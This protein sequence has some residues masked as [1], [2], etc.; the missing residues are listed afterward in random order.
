MRTH[1]LE[2]CSIK[3]SDPGGKGVQREGRPALRAGSASSAAS[4]AP[5]AHGKDEAGDEENQKAPLDPETKDRDAALPW[6]FRVLCFTYSAVGL[7]MV[8]RVQA[9][10]CNCPQYPWRVEAA[11]LLLQGLLSFLHDGY[12]AGSSPAAKLADRTSAT[13][14]T[15]CQPLKFTFCRMDAVQLG[16][17]FVSW[18]L[19]LLFFRAAGRAYASGDPRRYQLLHSLW[20]VAL[21]LGGFLWIEYTRG[22]LS[23]RLS[24]GAAAWGTADFTTLG[25]G[26]AVGINHSL[27]SG[28]AAALW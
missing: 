21:P 18:S 14:L 16:L 8:L 15:C 12:F 28:V 11:L 10:S 27:A 5:S 6:W 7:N 24:T 4:G 17:L 13:F 2:L 19:G 20:H 1:T 26:E 9:M 22:A 25:C 23:W 3:P